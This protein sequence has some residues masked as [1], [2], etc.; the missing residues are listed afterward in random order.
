MIPAELDAVL[1]N[2]P[3]VQDAAVIGIPNPVDREHPMG[4]VVLTTDSKIS[5]VELLKYYN[6]NFK[7]NLAF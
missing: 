3:D 1:L 5:E 4:V 6:G 7:S 2:H